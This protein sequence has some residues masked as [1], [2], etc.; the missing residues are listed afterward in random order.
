MKLRRLT[1]G[2]FAFESVLRRPLRAMCF[3]L[4]RARPGEALA[5]RCGFSGDLSAGR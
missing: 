1:F 5:N 4:S 3:L 2:P